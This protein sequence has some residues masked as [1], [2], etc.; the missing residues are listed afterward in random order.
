VNVDPRN[1]NPTREQ[2]RELMRGSCYVRNMK[3]GDIV[4]W[5]CG[6]VDKAG[7]KCDFAFDEDV[8]EHIEQADWPD[9]LLD[10]IWE[11]G[12][13][14]ITNS[15]PRERYNPPPLDDEPLLSVWA[16]GMVKVVL[17]M[18]PVLVVTVLSVY[19]REFVIWFL[20]IL[21][22][23]IIFGVLP[24]FLAGERKRR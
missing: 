24:F 23:I 11:N 13:I 1:V 21:V 10:H 18:L 12:H 3:P 8:T 16:R 14:T 19:A 5:S 2:V 20:S 17:L 7:K 15:G 4:H 9:R 6:H 22:T